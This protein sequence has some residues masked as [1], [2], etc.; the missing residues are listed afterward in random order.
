MHLLVKSQPQNKSS[1]LA[2]N[3]DSDPSTAPPDP[4]ADLNTLDPYGV[5]GTWMRIVC[6]LDYSDLYNF[7]F[8]NSTQSD[9]IMGADGQAEREPIETREAFRLIK[10]K[11]HVTSV[12][13]PEEG[14]DHPDFPVV[15]FEGTSRSM[16]NSWDPNA[17]SRIRGESCLLSIFA[18][19]L[20][21][22]FFAHPAFATLSSFV[23]SQQDH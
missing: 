7:N 1:R 13:D 17:N 18:V 22:P 2:N 4:A 15:S 3:D 20:G 23:P 5:A 10:L 21:T 19:L 6:F 8:D 11:L 16:L 14:V 12:D 9:P